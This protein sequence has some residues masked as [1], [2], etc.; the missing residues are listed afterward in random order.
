[1]T[2]PSFVP[3]TEADQVRPARRLHVPGPWSPDRPAEI[4]VPVRQHGRMMGTPG[5]DQGFALRLA[6]RMEDRLHLA[7][8]ESADDVLGGAALLAARRAGLFGRAPS[9]HDLV[10]ALSLWGFLGDAP[11]ELVDARRAA[12]RGAAHDYDVQRALVDS[13]PETS[14]RLA[15]DEVGSQAGGE[16]WRALVRAPE[17]EA[18]P[19]PA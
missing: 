8:G 11:R 12:F 16:G 10:V 3:I 1:M 4:R 13:V 18:T 6:R 9:V 7:A 15:P 5:P 14:L 2:Q 17:D 19:E